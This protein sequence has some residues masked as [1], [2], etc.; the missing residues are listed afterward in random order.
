MLCLVLRFKVGGKRGCPICTSAQPEQRRLKL[1]IHGHFPSSPSLE[2]MQFKGRRFLEYL[3]PAWVAVPTNAT[4]S[5]PEVFHLPPCCSCAVYTHLPIPLP[6]H[7][8]KNPSPCHQVQDVVDVQF[9]AGATFRVLGWARVGINS[10]TECLGK[11][12]IHAVR[13]WRV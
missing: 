1:D 13:F 5:L 7:P 12:K 10:E 6:T 2:V 8:L 3:N 4:F 11:P 9:P